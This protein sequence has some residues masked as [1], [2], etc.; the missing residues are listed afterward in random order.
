MTYR[1]PALLHATLTMKFRV[2]HLL[3]L[4]LVVG[5][6]MTHWWL[7]DQLQQCQMKIE[8]QELMTKTWKLKAEYAERQ[9][10][11]LWGQL[12]RCNGELKKY[13]SPEL[14]PSFDPPKWVRRIPPKGK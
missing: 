9:Y 8:G 2:H 4:M 10:G 6:W 11:E 7:Y 5:I 13:E 14:V 12:L 1:L 3:L